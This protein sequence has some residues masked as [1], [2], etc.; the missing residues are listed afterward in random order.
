[1]RDTYRSPACTTRCAYQS[2]LRAAPSVRAKDPASLI[3]V[4]MN[5][6]RTAATEAAPTGP[7]MPSY[8]W[9]LDDRQM[10]AVLTFVRNSWGNAAPAVPE[11]AVQSARA[12][13]AGSD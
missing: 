13:L 1:M 5:G 11:S 4:A 6:T 7:G 12:S 8:A 9:Q 2:A 10:A 3:R